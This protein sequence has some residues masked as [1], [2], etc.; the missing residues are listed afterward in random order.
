MIEEF[1]DKISYI[2]QILLSMLVFMNPVNKRKH[3]VVRATVGA[4]FFLILSYI[5]N[6]RISIP[7]D[8]VSNILYWSSFP[9]LIVLYGWFCLKAP[10]AEVIYCTVFASA[11][12]HFACNIFIL[13][14]LYF[15]RSGLVFVVT[16]AAVYLYFLLFFVRKICVDGHYSVNWVDYFPMVTVV[17]LVTILSLLEGQVE[18]SRAGKTIYYL[19]DSLC[20]IYIFWVQ[21]TQRQKLQLQKELDGVNYLW[22]QQKAQYVVSQEVIESINR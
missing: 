4:V 5:I 7:E 6:S 22:K 10:S 9:F 15:G 8:T 20:C 14:E 13:Y 2:T 3:Y 1:W 11:V 16:M 19:C 12:Q 18:Q 17:L 21:L